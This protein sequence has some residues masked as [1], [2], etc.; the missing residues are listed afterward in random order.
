MRQRYL[1]AFLPRGFARLC[2]TAAL[3]LCAALAVAQEPV[4]IGIP[5]GLS[6]S[7]SVIAP[8]ILQSSELAVA[9]I[10]AAGGILG[11]QVVLEVADDATSVIGAQ[12]AYDALV[13][14][15]KVDAIITMEISAARNAG[16]PIVSRGRVPYIYT[17]FY[18]GHACNRWM[19][20]N[21][22]VPEQQ[23]ATIVDY[24]T[25][26][27]KGK[28]FFLVGNDYNFGRNMFDYTRAYIKQK[29]GTVVGEEY[30]PLDGSDWTAIVAK[31]RA[32]APDAL[33]TATA[34][35]SANVGLAKQ[36]R[37]AGLN[38]HYGSLS[39]DE[40][41]AQNMGDAADGIYLSASYLTSI[42]N[43]ENKRFLAALKDKFG[44]QVKTQS[45]LSEPQYE[46]IHLYK[47]AVEKAGSFDAAKVVAAL[48]EVSFDGPRGVVSMN[49]Q[50]HAALT[51]RLAQVQKDGS[52]KTIKTFEHLDPGEQC[53]KL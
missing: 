3:G 4:R 39:L 9:E 34:G 13:F 25:D 21:G 19:H 31:V 47:A 16:L 53:P 52:L 23:V 11:R 41:T 29:G 51:M 10:N 44:E 35:G 49:R 45:D 8:A 14:Q 24:F 50:R 7:N 48:S 40:G 37:A 17:S 1:S 27:L 18:E 30:L 6:G 33:L 43:A 22:W 12:K 2:C 28:T 42:D 15:K 20:I 36:V 5:L 38:L 46:A 26:E 32:A